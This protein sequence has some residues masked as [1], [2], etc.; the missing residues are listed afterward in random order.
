MS[1]MLTHRD[2]R[3]SDRPSTGRQ[4]TVKAGPGEH[5]QA[6][7]QNRRPRNA[8]RFAPEVERASWQRGTR[9]TGT[10]LPSRC[11]FVLRRLSYSKPSLQRF[12]PSLAGLAGMGRRTFP[13]LTEQSVGWA[14]MGEG[15]LEMGKYGKSGNA[16]SVWCI[17]QPK[18]DGIL[19]ILCILSILSQRWWSGA[20]P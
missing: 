3:P 20:T 17:L 2:L 14:A 16:S 5:W 1:T 10:R 19:F 6:L 15:K 18:Q 11:V 12:L 8:G 9:T 4:G 13:P 7:T